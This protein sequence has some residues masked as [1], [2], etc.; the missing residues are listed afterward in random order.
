MRQLDRLTDIMRQ[1]QQILD[2]TFRAQQGGD[3]GQSAA[4][5][6]GQGGGQGQQGGQG[7]GQNGQAGSEGLKQRQDDLQKQLQEL[8][9]SM[10]QKGDGNAVQRKLK[11]AERAMGEAAGALE[12][13]ELGE[14]SDQEGQALEALRQGSR[15][16]AEQM[17]RS[18]QRGNG[19]SQSNRDPFG[20]RQGTEIN[21]TGENLISKDF[22]VQRARTILDEL[23]K[24]LGQPSRPPVELDYLERL[25]KP[26]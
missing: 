21:D 5:E 9:S 2:K 19:N 7:R 13:N 26:Y 18:A 6:R 12:Q 14:A 10:P 8:L 24:R 23:R 22:D 11:D 3:S 25:I 15:S 20:R 16:V 1:Q 17:M 4:G